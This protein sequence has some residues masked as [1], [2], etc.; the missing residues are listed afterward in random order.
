MNNDIKKLEER[1]K[2]L[3]DIISNGSFNFNQK[4]FDYVVSK[5]EL[6]N[7]L[8]IGLKLG[9]D[10]STLFEVSSN[11]KGVKFPS[12]TTT[13]RNAI[14]NPITGLLVFDSTIGEYYFYNGSVWGAIKGAM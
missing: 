14:V 6:G 12:L 10:S 4:V 2:T 1:V 7:A 5:L 8:G 3:E 9:N 11:T 13:E